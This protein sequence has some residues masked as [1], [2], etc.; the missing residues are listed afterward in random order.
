[1]AQ[2][3]HVHV[4]AHVN[5]DVNADVDVNGFGCGHAAP[6]ESVDSS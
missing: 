2:A 4:N 1:M 5:V 3:V 6:G